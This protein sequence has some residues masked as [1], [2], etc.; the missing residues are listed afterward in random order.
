MPIHDWTKVPAALFHD[1]QQSWSVGIATVLN[2][3]RLPKGLGALIERRQH[4]MES[5]P[6]ECQR[7][8]ALANL[9]AIKR[10]LT[11]T[12]AVIEIVSPG[13]KDSRAAL[14][15][16]VDKTLEFLKSGIHVLVIDLFPPSPRDPQGIHKVIWDEIVEEDF[17]LPPG[18]DR[19]LA[20]YETGGVRAA[21]AEM[22]GVGDKLPDMP[23][24][25]ANDFYV[26]VPLEP[27]Y[28]ATWSA[29]PE[30]MRIA[31]ET[32]VMPNPEEE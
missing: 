6:T 25:L 27:T 23:L 3:G 19:V 29:S 30:E 31:V 8:A 15:D 7:Y 24:Y 10:H 12:I 16:F 20:S 28:E 2:G 22:V 18:K 13:N 26:N 17:T 1:F 11:K 4:K 21:Y 14:R 9:V 5:N 32:G